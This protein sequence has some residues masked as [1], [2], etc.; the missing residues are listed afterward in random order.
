MIDNL[1]LYFYLQYLLY[2]ETLHGFIAQ[3]V[4]QAID[5]HEELADG[6]KMW[7]L[8]DDGT[9]TVADGNLVPMLVKAVQELSAKVKNL[10]KKCNC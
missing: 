5:N 1:L 4:K 3:E 2:G 10:E 6:F 7:K 9:Q 8:K